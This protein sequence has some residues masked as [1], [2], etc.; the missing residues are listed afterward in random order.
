MTSVGYYDP[1]DED[2]ASKLDGM[3]KYFKQIEE[4]E[5]NNWTKNNPKLY[6]EICNYVERELDLDTYLG[7][8]DIPKKKL[9]E[10]SKQIVA[11]MYDIFNLIPKDKE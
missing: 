9:R 3:D 7:K 4:K 1:S 2:N 11:I 10:V 6:K 5:K 8:Y